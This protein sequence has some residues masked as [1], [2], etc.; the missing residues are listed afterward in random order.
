MALRAQPAPQTPPA[1]QAVPQPPEPPDT[2]DLPEPPDPYEQSQMFVFNDHSVH[3][4]V[5]LDEVTAQKAQDLKLPAVA[6]ALVTEV[7]KGSAADKA[8]LQAGDVITDFDGIHV[9]S[10]AELRRL[11]RETPSGRTV[12]IKVFREGRRHTLSAKLEASKNQFWWKPPGQQYYPQIIPP[13]GEH[14]LPQIIPPAMGRR[15]TLGIEGD[16]LT[17]QLAKY[18]GVEQGAG[19][20]VSEVTLGG[21]ADKA[22]VKAGDV[23]TQVDGKPVRGVEELRRALNENFT[24]E[25]RKV[26]L[27]VVRDHHER[28]MTAELTRPRIE[29]DRTYLN[30]DP[31]IKMDLAELPA[32][33]GEIRAQAEDLRN[34][35]NRQRALI[36]SQVI[37]QQKILQK[38][39]QQQLQEQLQSL[40]GF[41]VQKP[42]SAAHGD[43]EI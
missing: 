41:D 15:V 13:P 37:E 9:R 20:L 7:Q 1:P 26:S 12:E 25:T 5:V 34:L 19:V 36:Q 27:T 40:K 21:A 3:L 2:P 11:I 29:Q 17:P 22:G 24:G 39:W 23:I 4:G 16:D 33:M 14:N 43:H 8:G 6:G 42:P 10:S 28:T 30:L 31:S 38:E 35:A 18:F 32:T